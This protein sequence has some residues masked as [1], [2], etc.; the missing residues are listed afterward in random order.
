MSMSICVKC[1]QCG[2]QYPEVIDDVYP[3]DVNDVMSQLL[4]NVENS[5]WMVDWNYG[6][7]TCPDCVKKNNK[8]LPDKI[9]WTTYVHSS[10]E[11]G[12]EMAYEIEEK[13]NIKLSDEVVENLMYCLY[14]VKV[15]LEINPKT[16]EYK[17]LS[18]KE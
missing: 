7:C 13:F 14:E 8:S 2:K 12:R 4:S 1:N 11:S 10:K 6:D 5:E 3:E 16:G 17:I 15:E 18:F 9:R